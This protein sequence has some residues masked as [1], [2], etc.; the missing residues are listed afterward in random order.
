MSSMK[1]NRS[2]WREFDCHEQLQLFAFGLADSEVVVLE[3]D[4]RIRLEA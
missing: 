2:P 1:V 4:E 3:V